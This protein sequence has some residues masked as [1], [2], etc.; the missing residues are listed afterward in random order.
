M[1]GCHQASIYQTAANSR[2]VIW[3]K[4]LWQAENG[5]PKASKRRAL[6]GYPSRHRLSACR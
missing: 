5:C 1:Y 4:G 2:L 6:T 3:S